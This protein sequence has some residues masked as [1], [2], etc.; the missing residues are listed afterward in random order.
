MLQHSCS[1]P[2]QGG[3]ARARRSLFWRLVLLG[4]AAPVLPFL[5]WSC[6]SYPLQ[7]PEPMPVGESAQY[8]E[9]NPINKVDIV[10]VIDNSGSMR[11]EQ[12]NLRDNFAMFM[13]QLNVP[14]ADLHIGVVSSDLGAGAGN[15]QTACSGPGGDNGVFCRTRGGVAGPVDRCTTCM[16]DV[17]GGRFLRTVNPNFT[18]SI[19][20]RFGCMANFGTNGCGFEHSI[21]ALQKALTSPENGAFVRDDAYLAF[22]IITDEDDCTAPADSQMFSSPTVGQDWSLRCALEAHTCG[23]VHNT[24]TENVDRPL[25]ECQ[26]APD[27]QLVGIRSMVDAVKAVKKGDENLIISAG[28]FGWPLPN[29]EAAARYRIASAGQGGF[30][31]R[32]MR[33]VCESNNGSATPAFRVQEFVKSFRNHSTFSICQDDF[34][35]AMQ[36]IGEKIKIILGSPCIDRP[37]VDTNAANPGIDPDCAVTETRPGEAER[38]LPR[39]KDGQTEPCWQVI[40]DNTCAFSQHKIEIDRKGQPVTEGTKQTIKCLTVPDK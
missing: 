23:G 29:E 12:Q 21:G 30:G 37:L 24:G 6:N 19:V 13:Q 27:G 31:E 35:E 28:I 17:T 1:A 4:S 7:K 40:P 33:P 39:C 2:K 16:V 34:S 5:L 25:A 15:P 11:E 18:G 22:I 8:R 14:G 36:K 32:G 20:Q 10:F 26:A 38:F 3:A 9:V